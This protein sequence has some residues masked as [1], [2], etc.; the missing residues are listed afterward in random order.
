MSTITSPKKTPDRKVAQ[1]LT[2]GSIVGIITAIFMAVFHKNLPV[3]VITFLP[4]ALGVL[5][6]FAGSYM[7]PYQPRIA[8]LLVEAKAMLAQLGIN[9]NVTNTPPVA[10]SSITK[11]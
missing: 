1:G 4:M 7:A 10:T 9:V 11:V 2:T 6:H 8:E 3:Q 5:G